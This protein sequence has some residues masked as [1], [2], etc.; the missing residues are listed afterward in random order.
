M[1]ALDIAQITGKKRGNQQQNIHWHRG[2]AENLAKGGPAEV[3]SADRDGKRVPSTEPN[4]E[5]NGEQV[6]GSQT[7]GHGK[8]NHC[9][10]LYRSENKKDHP[11]GNPV[12][13]KASDQLKNDSHRNVNGHDPASGII[14]YSK[15]QIGHIKN[16]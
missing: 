15:Y 3:L 14:N 4:P 6:E 13:Y 1:G 8:G 11:I 7:A 9:A 16:M 12:S 10:R 5:E 2:K